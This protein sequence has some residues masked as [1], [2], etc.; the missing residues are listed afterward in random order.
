MFEAF[1]LTAIQTCWSLFGMNVAASTSNKLFF[2]RASGI[3][4]IG[5]QLA[6]NEQA[7]RSTN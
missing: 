1:K 2:S 6:S 7:I 5:S 3:R 4:L